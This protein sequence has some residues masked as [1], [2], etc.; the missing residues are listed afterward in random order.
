MS[1][2]V[3]SRSSRSKR[4]SK[5]SLV[6]QARFTELYLKKK[7]PSKQIRFSFSKSYNSSVVANSFLGVHL[8]NIV[9]GTQINQ[10]TSSF[11]YVSGVKLDMTAYNTHTSTRMLRIM[12]VRPKNPNDSFDNVGFTDLLENSSFAARTPDA[13]SGDANAPIN[14]DIVRVICDKRYI[15]PP[16]TDSAKS[17]NFWCP[18]RK[19]IEYKTVNNNSAVSNGR[20]YIVGHLC[21]INNG[22]SA[23][24]MIV[25]GMARVY[26]SEL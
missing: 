19:K 23:N 12:V 8:T 9:T 16:G 15:I 20:I 2:I 25:D 22:S 24:N 21:E 17:I 14:T 1:A 18:I 3:K 4:K 6:K 13:L 7:E 5:P 11:I 26:Y 10:K